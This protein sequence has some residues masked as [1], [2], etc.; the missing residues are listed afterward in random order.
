MK[1]SIVKT[2]AASGV[3]LA[4]LAP[5][6]TLAANGVILFRGDISDTTCSVA[7]SSPT[8]SEVRFDTVKPDAII[9][10]TA[11]EKVFEINLGGGA[12]CVNGKKAYLSF[13]RNDVDL[14]SNNVP[15]NPGGAGNVQIEISHSVAGVKGDKVQL[16]H[17]GALEA[18][19]VD[20]A[21]KYAFVAQYVR[22]DNQAAVTP[23]DGSARLNFT[24]NV[25]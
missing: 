16:G 7:V 19:I 18:E 15:L 23:G 14:V 9:A 10:G 11:P 12:D 2:L 17:V 21:A 13:D 22:R 24:V 5:A 4:V 20:N 8:G 1:R 3:L 6:A 25:P